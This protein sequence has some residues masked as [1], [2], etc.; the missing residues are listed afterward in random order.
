[1]VEPEVAQEAEKKHGDQGR[2]P[3]EPRDLIPHGGEIL[4]ARVPRAERFHLADVVAGRDLVASDDLLVLAHEA[5]VLV[6]ALPGLSAERLGGRSLVAEV[7]LD[8]RRG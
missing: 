3:Q 6:H 1:M 5:V 2:A 4:H 7:G 8:H